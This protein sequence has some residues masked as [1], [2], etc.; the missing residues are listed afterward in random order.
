MLETHDW[1]DKVQRLLAHFNDLSVAHQ[2]LVQTRRAE[3]LLAPV[4][5]RGLAYRE[6]SMELEAG[7]R[8]LEAADLFFREETVRL[9]E[10]EIER[11]ETRL[12]ALVNKIERLTREMNAASQKVRQLQNDIDK[13]GGDR[14]RAI[15]SLLEVER[16]KLDSKRRAFDRFHTELRRCRIQD[17]VASAAAFQPMRSRLQALSES[18][19][20]AMATASGAHEELIGQRGAIRHQLEVER[21]ELAILNDRQ[22][23]LPPRLAMLRS[24]LCSDLQLSEDVLPF[25]AEL[26]AVDPGERRWEASA[27]MVLRAFALSLLVPGRFYRRVRAYVEQNRMADDRGEGQRL[28]YIRVGDGAEPK[29]DRIHPQSLFRKLRFRERHPLTPWV[30]GEVQ[31]RFDYRCC[32]SVEEFNETA[33]FAM[34]ENRHIKVGNDRHQKDDRAR[35][36]DRRYFVLGWDNREKKR[37][38]ADNI[39]RLGAELARVDR[40]VEESTGRLEELRSVRDAARA[41][42]ETTDFDDIDVKRH[43]DEI[44]ALEKERKQ[45]EESNDKVKSLKK[46]LLTAEAELQN[47]QTDRNKSHGEKALL[48]K[49]IENAKKLVENAQ[50]KVA[51][52][53]QAG[54]YDAH[55]ESFEAIRDSLGEPVLSTADLFERENVWTKN[56]RQ[57]VESMRKPLQAQAEK[58]IESMSRFLREFK[59]EQTDL[60]ATVQSLDSFLGRLEQIRKEDLP[61]YEKKFKDRLNDKVSQ[62][63]ALF[64]GALRQ[65]CKQI[66]G[67]IEQLNQALAQLEYQQGTF[68]RLE[69]RHVQDVE[70]EDFRR[71]LRECLD[72]SLENTPEANEARFSRIQK[73][74]ERLGD[75]ERTRWRDK[76]IDVRNWYSFAAREVEKETEATRSYHEGSSGQ[77]GGEKAKLAFTILVAAIAYQYDLDP[78]GTTPGRFHFVIVD[79]MFSKVD[80]Q[81]AQYA[82][83]LFEQFGLQLLI[84]APLDAKARVTEPFVDSYLH[85]VKDDASNRSQLYSMTAQEYEEVVKGFSGNGKAE[86][87]AR[88][89]AK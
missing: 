89:S 56:R 31:R 34:T 42:L 39:R 49:E 54:S 87:F 23:N 20:D 86:G 83:R 57:Q 26:M 71:S 14:L 43:Q 4:E 30:R 19:A 13:A 22:T 44:A 77:S 3:E 63:V 53:K 28:D 58:L 59:E 78:T 18:N 82:L 21:E 17:V 67:K 5:K 52:V 48:E 47:I 55:R 62:E 60:N 9:F 68:M 16:T 33:R 79:E 73:L 10:P 50:R 45:L 76:V 29:G 72:E 66:E 27:E 65:E 41:A 11:H 2:E 40:L 25:A 35:T 85:V 38:I 37:L 81:N 7:E 15:P 8:Q 64:H 1:R 61:R 51:T 88:A 69:P 74:V 70:I 12:A 36:I 32:E 46:S 75:K 6:Q 24:R 80:D 84:V